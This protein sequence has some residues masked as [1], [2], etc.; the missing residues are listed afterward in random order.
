MG[1][2]VGTLAEQRMSEAAVP[3][4]LSGLVINAKAGG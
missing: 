4:G 3:C 2:E 1:S